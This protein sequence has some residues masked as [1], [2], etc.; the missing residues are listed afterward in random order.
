MSLSPVAGA[1]LR[2]DIAGVIEE[3]MGSDELLIGTKL[4]PPLGVDER[5]GQYP[6]LNIDT[7][8][9]LAPGDVKRRGPTADYARKTRQWEEDTYTCLE[10]G[11]EGLLGLDTITDLSR[12]FDA[13]STV[14]R[15]TQSDLLLA[16]EIRVAGQAFNEDNFSHITSATAY[17]AA[18][19]EN[20]DIGFDIDLAKEEIRKRGEST[21]SDR[22][23]V[24]IPGSLYPLIRTSKRLQQRVFGVSRS[25]DTKPLTPQELAEA[26]EVREVLIGRSSYNAGKQGAA[27]S[28]TDVWAN[29]HI[30]V[31]QVSNGG[32]L[33]AGG[34]GR[35]MFWQRDGNL[36]TV[37]TYDV[38]T[39]RSLAIRVRHTTDEKIV[40]ANT[41][42]LIRT[43][44]A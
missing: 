41:A 23:T 6:R 20:F 14:A 2:A 42:Q 10:Y 17:T 26:F 9:L 13:E 12:F 32:D 24:V 3:A 27:K 8:R 25:A 30:W 35:T 1:I 4:F 38:P 44:A 7:G 40:N 5:A 28:L 22:L 18:N 43:Q 19:V 15:L 16:H 11:L 37:E 36:V 21:A 31:G 34:A 39:K 33:M 29:T